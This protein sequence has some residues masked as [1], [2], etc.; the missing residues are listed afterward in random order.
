[1]MKT[2]TWL[3]K[4]SGLLSHMGTAWDNALMK[5]GLTGDRRALPLR[6]PLERVRLEVARRRRQGQK[7]PA[8]GLPHFLHIR[9]LGMAWL[10]LFFRDENWLFVAAIHR[11][12]KFARDG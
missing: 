7:Y 5:D 9:G 10:L 3:Q 12:G 6:P 11:A 4:R 8:M 1:M 2:L